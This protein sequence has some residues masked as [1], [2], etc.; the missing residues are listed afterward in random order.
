MREIFQIYAQVSP[1]SDSEPTGVVTEG[2]YYIEDGTLTMCDPEGV[3][4]RGGIDGNRL[5]HKLAK[6]ENPRTI[7]ARLCLRRFYAQ[8]DTN[9]EFHRRISPREYPRCPC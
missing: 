9:A 2:W 4:I 5:T 8:R 3:V 7:A 1:C 6:G